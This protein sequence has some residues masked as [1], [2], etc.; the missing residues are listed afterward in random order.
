MVHGAAISGINAV[1]KILKQY[2]LTQRNKQS[3]EDICVPGEIVIV[4]AGAAGL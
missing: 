3:K 1:D 4:G 2:R